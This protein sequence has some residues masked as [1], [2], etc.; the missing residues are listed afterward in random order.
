M[1]NNLLNIGKLNDT[2]VGGWLTAADGM[3]TVE[4]GATPRH[5]LLVDTPRVELFGIGFDYIVKD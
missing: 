1:P 5:V 4:Q 2:M 3:K